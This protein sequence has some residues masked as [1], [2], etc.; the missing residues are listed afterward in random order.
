MLNSKS[1]KLHPEFD[2]EEAKRIYAAS[3]FDKDL[4]G[5]LIT[6]PHD[7]FPSK[8]C[9]IGSLCGW[10]EQHQ[11]MCSCLGTAKHLVWWI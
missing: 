1:K 6:S 8:C 2:L 10:G 9:V 5:A 3:Q 4:E 11:P 7:L